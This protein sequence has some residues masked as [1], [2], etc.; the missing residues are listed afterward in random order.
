ML[1]SGEPAV[2]STADVSFE[3]VRERALSISASSRLMVDRKIPLL[4]DGTEIEVG[5]RDSSL[6]RR[7]TRSQATA[8]AFTSVR[9]RD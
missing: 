1:V 2:N 8:I 9:Q 6:V 4:T 5:V 3:P 7:A